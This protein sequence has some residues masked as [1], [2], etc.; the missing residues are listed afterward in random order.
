MSSAK[1]GVVLY[2]ANEHLAP[3][4]DPAALT[5][6]LEASYRRFNRGGGV[7][8]PR[9]DL[10]IPDGAGGEAYQFGIAVGG[11]AG[12]YV[13]LRIKSDRVYHRIINGAA[14]KEKYAGQPG[15]YLGLVM[16]FDTR[17]GALLAI[18]QD[19]LL[20]RMRVG[21]DSAI[22]VRLMARQGSSR[23]AL[24][25]AGGMA[26]THIAAISKVRAL[27]EIRVFSPTP[28]NREKFARR[29]CE[30]YGLNVIAVGS[31]KEA[32]QGADILC[33]CTNSPRPVVTA[34]LLRP[35]MHITAIGGGLDA[36][37]SARVDRAVRF[38]SANPPLG[39][40]GWSYRDE[41]LV[42]A[43]GD[44]GLSHGAARHFA[45]IPANREI[46]FA[47]MDAGVVAREND[48][49]ITFSQRG[50]IHG[51]QFAAAAG[52]VY[53]QA[54]AAGLGVALGD[55]DGFFQDIRN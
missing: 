26:E 37:A 13:A 20:Q 31:A 25:G 8:P 1:E 47:D 2:L 29:M 18:M 51:L 24:L 27:Q 32:S 15:S 35:G 9:I 7:T 5:D 44:E 22:G 38:G 3:V 50:N 30:T 36:E 34:E 21:C 46:T 41:A 53:E 6:R 48:R 10:Q 49:Q 28:G 17:S 39:V 52:F 40:D 19:G 33:S 12:G 4:L 55:V 54:K 42:F 16:L 11:E 14:R 45:D 43:A 23:L